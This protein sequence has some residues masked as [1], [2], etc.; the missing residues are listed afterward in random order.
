[1][2]FV[3]IFLQKRLKHDKI[4]DLY[5]Q[6]NYIFGYTHFS[7]KNNSNFLHRFCFISYSTFILILILHVR[8]KRK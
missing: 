3:W 5:P 6:N 2:E 1:M 4:K 8:E 7:V